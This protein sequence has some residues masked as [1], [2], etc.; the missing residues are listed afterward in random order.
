[1]TE[2]DKTSEDDGKYD[3]RVVSVSAEKTLALILSIH[4]SCKNMGATPRE[5]IVLLRAWRSL[6]EH[7]NEALRREVTFLEAGLSKLEYARKTVDEL[8]DAAIRQEK[9]LREAQIAADRAMD[10]ITRALSDATDR[11]REVEEVKKEVT[12]AEAETQTRKTDIEA[13]LAQITPILESAQQAVGS[14]RSEH[15]NEI[16]TLP[17]PPEAIADVLSAVLMLLGV[18]DHSWLSMKK[19]LGNRG[20]KEEIM[21]FDASKI[22]LETRKEVSKLIKKKA[23]SFEAAAIQ[24]V[25]V[26]AAPLA[27]WVKANIRY[28]LVLEKIEPLDQQLREAEAVL[29]RSQQRLETCASELREIDNRVAEIKDQFSRKTA[30]AQMLRNSLEHAEATL[31][32]ASALIH[33]LSGE[34][35]R[36]EQQ[37]KTLS[38]QLSTLPLQLLLAAGF[39]TYLVKAPEDVR[40]AVL[41]QWQQI[42]GIRNFCFK[43]LMSTESLLL[44][45]KSD[46]LP[47]DA[48]S[49]ENA[50]VITYSTLRVPFIIDPASAATTWLRS[51]LSSDKSRPLEVVNSQDPRFSNHTELAVRF[52]K[53]LLVLEVDGLEPFLYPLARKDLVHQGP[54]YMVQLGD[55]SIDYNENFRLLLATRNPKP[56]LLPDAAALVTLINF[57]VTRSGLEGQLLG[58]TI[59]NEMPELETAKGEMLK[60]EEDFKVQLAMLEKDLLR[61]LAEAEGNILENITLI[62]SLTRTKEKAGEIEEALRRSADAGEQ[63]DQ[64]R[65]VYREFAL[66]GARLFFLVKQLPAVNNMYQFSLNSFVQLFIGTL[67]K[68]MDAKDTRERLSKLT[69]SF[70]VQVLHFVGRALFKSDRV[71]FALHLIKGMCTDLFY[72]KEWSVFTEAVVSA[73]TDTIPRGFPSWAA[74]D[75]AN[76]FQVLVDHLP[77]MVYG[78]ELDNAKWERFA[79][80]AEPERDFP[81][82]RGLSS[83]QKVLLVQ[84]FRPDRLQSALVNFCCD[85][86]KLESVSPPSPSLAELYADSDSRTPILLITTAGTDPSKQLQE[87]ARTTVGTD[88][89]EELAMGGGQQDIAMSLLRNAVECGSWLCLKNLHLVVAW[90][91][92][93]EKELSVLLAQSHQS[94]RLWLT[95]E[96][97]PVFPSILLQMSLKATFES[98]AGLKKNLL[99]TL[100]SWDKAF[101]DGDAGVEEKVGKQEGNVR[102]K[103]LYLLACFHAVIQERRNYI[104]QGWNKFYEFS[105]GDLR[106]GTFLMDAFGTESSRQGSKAPD[107]KAI[108][109]LMEDAIYGGR[110]DNTFDMRVLGTYLRIFFNDRRVLDSSASEIVPGLRMPKTAC[111]DSF[112]KAVNQVCLF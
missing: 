59:K 104:P 56:E 95:T 8:S 86:L 38:E 27:A 81:V 47:A 107:W 87:F 10:Q 109:G 22:S 7:K 49:Q 36:W 111:F 58:T 65:E 25:S 112:W 18:H 45:W 64:Q 72:D 88:R 100:S 55:K 93:L 19:F 34:Q 54:R 103:L 14:M 92:Q 63:L 53:T 78:L 57:T 97:H 20:V 70:V 48:L 84:A 68:P 98:P 76:A 17:A 26:A 108:Y 1:V 99:R 41:S 6:Y 29:E 89:Y 52:G 30:E 11:R 90:L 46:G 39:S 40:S 12:I 9:E 85:S 73:I 105:Y 33:Q 16:R 21:T 80:S 61:D 37:A 23:Q 106:A 74:P 82:M 71:M 110:I 102:A 5:F 15:L 51:V 42:S 43:R 69:P 96:M 2:N 79:N 32:K 24:R 101:V 44:M 60:R 3:G 94:F 67:R 75:R 50:L 35:Q 77:Q 31:S 83:F 4:E 13:E 66:S 28:S 62:S 91:P